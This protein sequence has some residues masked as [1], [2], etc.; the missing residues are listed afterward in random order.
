M[1]LFVAVLDLTLIW[2]FVYLVYI[3]IVCVFICSGFGPEVHMAV[4]VS[5]I[6]IYFIVC[7]FSAV[8]DL[9]SIWLFVYNL[10]QWV[11]FSYVFIALCLRYMNKGEGKTN[12]HLVSSCDGTMVRT[13]DSQSHGFGF[14][15]RHC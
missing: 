11:G 3:Y 12:K 4:C 8:S 1:C 10:F 5:C 7:L 6:Y 15:S 2:L 13:Q 9:K 14:E